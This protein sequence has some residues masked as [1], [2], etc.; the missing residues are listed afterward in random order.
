MHKTLLTLLLI[1]IVLLAACSNGRG[2]IEASPPTAPEQVPSG[3]PLEVKP[4]GGNNVVVVFKRSGGFAGVDEEWI[5]YADGRLTLN[6]EPK[7]N[8]TAEQTLQLVSQIED[9]GFFELDNTYLPVNTCCDRFSFELT[10][11]TDDKSHTVRTIDGAEDTPAEFWE[12]LKL[13]MAHL[14]AQ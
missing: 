8:M 12:I 1:T 14:D 6:G 10:I 3:T 2:A 11:S 9:M 4:T 7:S 5:S 13:V